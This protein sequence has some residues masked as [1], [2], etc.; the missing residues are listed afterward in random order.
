MSLQSV[1]R[2]AKYYSIPLPIP[3][4]VELLSTLNDE[5]LLDHSF[6]V[7]SPT[8]NAISEI[9][10]K[11]FYQCAQNGKEIKSGAFVADNE[12][13][14]EEKFANTAVEPSYPLMNLHRIYSLKESPDTTIN[15]AYHKFLSNTNNQKIILRWWKRYNLSVEV[16]EVTIEYQSKRFN[17]EFSKLTV[18]YLFV[19]TVPE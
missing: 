13:L 17:E 18:G 7:I 5:W 11:Q 6:S 14:W 10:L 3:E 16:E 8:A 12:S 15:T 19:H 9:V 1:I 2:E 4:T